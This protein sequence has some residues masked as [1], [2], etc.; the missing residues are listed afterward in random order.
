[1]NA[2][3]VSTGAIPSG[4]AFVS[5][6]RAVMTW[7]V[8]QPV[9]AATTVVAPAPVAGL[10]VTAAAA[11]EPGASANTA[12][13]MR[14]V[15]RNTL[16]HVGRFIGG[17]PFSKGTRHRDARSLDPD[18]EHG[19]HTMSMSGILSARASAVKR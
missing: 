16:T 9:P 4:V 8:V 18:P 3:A 7:P 15:A 1:M 11:D 10:N 19:E 13:S 6:Q 5:S 17:E 12:T 2:P 14:T